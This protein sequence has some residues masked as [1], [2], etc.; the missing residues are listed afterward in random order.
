MLK[1]V[2]RYKTNPNTK[3]INLTLDYTESDGTF[4]LDKILCFKILLHSQWSTVL[5]ATPS[6]NG[7]S[8]N[9]ALAFPPSEAVALA[10]RPF[11]LA[12]FVKYS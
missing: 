7:W 1:S 5:G 11:S 10:L 2:P 6:G 3:P 8:R 4:H 9:Q 12:L